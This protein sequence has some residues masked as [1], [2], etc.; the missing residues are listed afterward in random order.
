L[1]NIAAKGVQDSVDAIGA[2]FEDVTLSGDVVYFEFCLHEMLD[3][4]KAL[5]HARALASDTRFRL[6]L[7]SRGGG[8]SPSRRRGHDRFRIRRRE[9]FRTAQRAYLDFSPSVE[10]CG[11][12]PALHKP[13]SWPENPNTPIAARGSLGFRV[14]KPAGSERKYRSVF[15]GVQSGPP[16]SRSGKSHS[17]RDVPGFCGSN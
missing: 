17:A 13:D 11:R 10:M 14:S 12:W 5:A 16:S 8:K 3:P 6:V 7:L 9:T 15:G 4:Q 2:E 1:L